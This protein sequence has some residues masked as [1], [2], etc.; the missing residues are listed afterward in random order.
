M[1]IPE[2]DPSFLAK[3]Y[4]F[5]EDLESA[6][7]WVWIFDRKAA[8]SALCLFQHIK[9]ISDVRRWSTFLE[10]KFKSDPQNV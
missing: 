7:Y 1:K 10:R 5:V 9:S 8:F 3:F 6:I 4:Q 2:E